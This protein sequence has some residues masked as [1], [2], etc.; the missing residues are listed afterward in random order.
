MQAA[1]QGASEAGPLLESVESR[2]LSLNE[3]ARET[4]ARFRVTRVRRPSLSDNALVTTNLSRLQ[5]VHVRDI[6][7]HEAYHFTQWLLANA[8]VLADV[9]GMELELTQA[10]R[11]VGDFSLDLIGRDSN[12]GVVIVENQLEQTDHGHLGQ[13][14]TY[15]GGTDPATIVW[16]APSF[17]DAHRAALDWLNDH[18]DEG[19]RFF[20]V[21]VSAVR[22]D[23][24]RP[25]PLF[26]LVAKPN[27]WTKQVHSETSVAL[28]GKS[29]LY[30]DFWTKLLSRI[31][32]AHPAWTRATGSSQQSWITLPYGKSSPWYSLLFTRTGAS[33][34][35]YFGSSNQAANT[36]EFERFLAH[37]ELLESEMGAPLLFDELPGKKACRIRYDRPEGGDVADADSHPELLGWFLDAFGR[38]RAA[39]QHVKALIEG[40]ADINDPE[41]KPGL[42]SEPRQT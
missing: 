18:T 30:Y 12:G 3:P 15:A 29:A 34:E 39:T 8:D 31:R 7:K 24:S 17:R 2:P 10:E 33:V 14:L 38:F 27:D 40:S 6:W 4:K 16:C 36:A 42:L 21:E 22:I 20:G 9:L 41:W 32:E 1:D 19:I 26:R 37:R 13:L 25:A 28:S 11:K 23:D 5:P 35:L